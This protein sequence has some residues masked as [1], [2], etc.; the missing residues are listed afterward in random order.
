VALRDIGRDQVLA[1][2]AEYDW[3]GQDGFLAAYGFQPAREYLLVHDRRT[4]DSK[5]VVG[6]AH[7]F[8]PGG[9]LALPSRSAPA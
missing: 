4:Y 9:I 8:L 7:G 3:L 6:V 5:A 1:A 2:I